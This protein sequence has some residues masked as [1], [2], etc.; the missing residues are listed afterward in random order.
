MLKCTTCA[1][2][3]EPVGADGC[4][5][6]HACPPLS[7][8]ELQAAVDAGKVILPLGETV[9][10]AHAKR[11]YERAS[12]RDENI[13]RDADAKH[14]TRIKAEGRGVVVIAPGDVQPDV[15]IV[16]V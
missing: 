13:R 15:V 11:T 8:V 12:K 9:T 6:F 1:G 16:D 2:T 4:L 3:Y 14:P 10:D 7:I 5:Y